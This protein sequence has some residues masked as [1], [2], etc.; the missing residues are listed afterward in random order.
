MVNLSLDMEKVLPPPEAEVGE[1]SGE[2]DMVPVKQLANKCSSNLC[3][4]INAKCEVRYC[5]H[6]KICIEI[7]MCNLG[8]PENNME[9]RLAGR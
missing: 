1:P 2:L 6:R 9:V 3:H 4:R 5:S 7:S 8:P